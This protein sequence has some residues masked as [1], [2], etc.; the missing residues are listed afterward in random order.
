M[1]TKA[2]MSILMV[3]LL[4]LSV[5]AQDD[6]ADRKAL[7]QA[8]G[9]QPL[10]KPQADREAKQFKIERKQLG[11]PEIKRMFSGIYKTAK[12]DPKTLDAPKD[13]F[14]G[15]WDK[16]ELKAI[17][18]KA[19]KGK[20]S[21]KPEQIDP[22]VPGFGDPAPPGPTVPE[23]GVALEPAPHSTLDSDGRLARFVHSTIS[24]HDRN[25]DGVLDKEEWAGA[26]DHLTPADTNRDGRLTPEEIAKW[27][28]EQMTGQTADRRTVESQ[29]KGKVAA[30]SKP[31]PENGSNSHRSPTPHEGA[32]QSEEELPYWFVE[33]DANRDGQVAMA[34]YSTYWT[35]AIAEEFMRH[36]LNNDGMVTPQ[37]CLKGPSPQANE[38]T[39]A[40]SSPPKTVKTRKAARDSHSQNTGKLPPD[41]RVASISPSTSKAK[42]SSD[43]KLKRYLGEMKRKKV[44][45]KKAAG[46]S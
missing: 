11:D 27:M 9:R 7:K 38:T 3:A 25:G 1:P 28:T 21:R 13:G 43:E 5:A 16:K 35:D 22:L 39:V 4:A 26:L 17:S 8:M 37:E 14:F 23:F 18:N 10:Q 29:P 42:R 24:R 6:K 41:Q 33:K 36:D 2:V 46:K 40:S 15:L 45:G 32:K 34:E 20:D 19:S 30:N 44:A 31:S 12:T